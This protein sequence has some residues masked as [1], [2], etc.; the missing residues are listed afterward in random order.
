M[1]VP[2][3]DGA[4]NGNEAL[5]RATLSNRIPNEEVERTVPELRP[6]S[7]ANAPDGSTRR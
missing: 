5:A 4:V 6:A 1:R 3:P 2:C 7:A